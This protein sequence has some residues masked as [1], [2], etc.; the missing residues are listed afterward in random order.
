MFTSVSK[1]PQIGYFSAKSLHV[2][3]SGEVLRTSP[4][5]NRA[6]ALRARA[7]WRLSPFASSAALPRCSPTAIKA[8]PLQ[9]PPLGTRARRA[10][11][12]YPARNAQ[13]F[14]RL[15]LQVAIHEVVL[16]EAAESFADVAGPGGAD[17]LHR[18]EVAL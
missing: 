15:K 14:V 10:C 16:L 12:V 8:I 7:L 11:P 5:E 2:A 4:E 9:A 17:S 18:L 3:G 1:V 13:H 6:G